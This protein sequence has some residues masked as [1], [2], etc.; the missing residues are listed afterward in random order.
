VVE[1]HGGELYFEA[2]Q[3]GT[4]VKVRL[5]RVAGV[6]VLPGGSRLSKSVAGS[7]DTMGTE[8][9]TATEVVR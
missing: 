5:P 8:P 2:L 3:R 7:G 4:R 1:G 9:G 6:K